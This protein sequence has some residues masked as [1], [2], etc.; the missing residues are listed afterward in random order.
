MLASPPAAAPSAMS[1]SSSISRSTGRLPRTAWAL[2]WVS[3][4]MDMSSEMIHAVLPVYM[5]SV[6]G[7]SLLTIGLVEGVA[8]ATASLLKMVS[9]VWSDRLGRR[10]TLAL[11]G[12]GLSAATKP[13]FPLASGAAGIIAA[14]WLDRVGK[15]IRGAPRDALLA[16]ATPAP[17]RDAAYGLR[18][19]MD[20]VGAFLGPLAAMV[21]LG[22]LPGRLRHVLWFGVLPAVVAVAVLALGVREPQRTRP[23]AG[24]A[25][26]PR[27][28]MRLPRLADARR[29][30][31]AY[32]MVVATA[33]VFTLAR[34][35]EAFLVLRGR[36][37]GLSLHWI[38][39]VTLGFSLVYALSALPAGLL[40]QRR[41]RAPVLAAGM[42]VLLGS[43]LALGG[44]SLPAL[45]LGV[46][47]YGLHLGL[48]QG[49]FAAAV[50]A[51]APAELRGSAF[52]VFHLCTG[53]L[54]LLA[55]VGAGWIW[56]RFGAAR[57]FEAGAVLAGAAL[58]LS[59]LARAP[60]ARRPG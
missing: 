17:L 30:P 10:K 22:W 20:T 16:D 36:Q 29:L 57:A 47:L 43:M 54:Q 18:Q 1:R 38:P 25:R 14:R 5:S 51:T 33:G 11:L 46:A 28:G 2:G 32:W 52:G 9:G 50:A 37:L 41:G 39:L 42:V 19:S 21:L 35:S 49:V 26:A 31:A 34:L 6:L 58:G 60:R 55:A 13:L 45:W 8:E 53:L 7:F 3:L 48:T 27:G 15:G 12:Y 4:F 40:A 44:D 24:A 23:P 56:E 59:L